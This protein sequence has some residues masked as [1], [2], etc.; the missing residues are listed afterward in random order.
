MK[1]TGPR[2][3]T[4]HTVYYRRCSIIRNWVTRTGSPQPDE[5]EWVHDEYTGSDDRRCGCGPTVDE[6]IEQ[7]DEVLP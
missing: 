4:D 3:E 7:I 6:C 1:T 5:W 2:D